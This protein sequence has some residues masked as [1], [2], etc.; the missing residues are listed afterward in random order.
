MV[1]ELGAR[2][3]RIV[4][5]PSHGIV[6]SRLEWLIRRGGWRRIGGWGLGRMRP[7]R[8]RLAGVRML[9]VLPGVGL[10]ASL[11]FFWNKST[12]GLGDAE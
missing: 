7:M 9:R 8:R 11:R 2:D 12:L 3:R 5:E 1:M 4:L 10:L 6:Q